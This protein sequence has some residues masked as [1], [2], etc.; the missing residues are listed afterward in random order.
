LK[1]TE[2]KVPVEKYFQERMNEMKTIVPD[3][4]YEVDFMFGTGDP[5]KYD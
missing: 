3:D 2:I 4:V 5:F 1:P